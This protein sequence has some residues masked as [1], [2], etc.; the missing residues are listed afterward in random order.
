M[1]GS[2]D[3]RTLKRSPQH[4]APRAP[5]RQPGWGRNR[6]AHETRLA[7]AAVG[8]HTTH[9]APVG[10]AINVLP[11]N[12]SYPLM[13]LYL[14]G[15]IGKLVALIPRTRYALH[16]ALFEDNRGVTFRTFPGV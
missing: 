15:F 4:S 5:G 6:T 3:C 7:A 1:V 16:A 13:A 8:L 14:H 12:S 10:L 9:S 11:N 2:L